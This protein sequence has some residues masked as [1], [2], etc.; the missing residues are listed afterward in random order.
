MRQGERR[1]NKKWSNKLEN[2]ASL[3]APKLPKQGNKN[4]D[5]TKLEPQ[6]LGDLGAPEK[7]PADL[8]SARKFP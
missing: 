4:E 7:D 5:K 3:P 1:R 6:D 8:F 2:S